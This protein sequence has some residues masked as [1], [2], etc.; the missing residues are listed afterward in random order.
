MTIAVGPGM[1]GGSAPE[2][3][4][5]AAESRIVFTIPLVFGPSHVGRQ[6]LPCCRRVMLEG[7]TWNLAQTV[8]LT[9]PCPGGRGAPLRGSPGIRSLCYIATSPLCRR[10]YSRDDNIGPQKRGRY[11]CAA[12][13]PTRPKISDVTT[14]KAATLCGWWSRWIHAQRRGRWQPAHG[15]ATCS[16]RRH[17]FCCT[18]YFVILAA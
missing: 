7:T 5:N 8:S 13:P 16:Q 4:P 9:D 3:E 1:I 6:L 15:W 17:G 2:C 12:R 18:R 11:R 14:R 10:R